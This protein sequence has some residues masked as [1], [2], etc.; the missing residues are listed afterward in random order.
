[1][2][3]RVISALIFG[4]SIFM[5]AGCQ[6]SEPTHT[7]DWYQAHATEMKAKLHAC[8]QN[9]GEL[10]NTPN[11]KNAERAAWL[12]DSHAKSLQLH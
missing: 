7:V 10:R 8:H 3:T 9:P 5:L 6:P 12:K 11:C 1:M 2:K 4:A